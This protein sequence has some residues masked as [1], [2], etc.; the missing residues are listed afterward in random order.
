MS[1]TARAILGLLLLALTLNAQN[2]PETAVSDVSYFHNSEQVLGAG[3]DGDGFLVIGRRDTNL[4]AH[5]VT[6]GGAVLDSTGIRLASR[7]GCCSR[8]IRPQGQ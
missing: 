1:S 7:T 2:F 3:S 4:F 8:R 5:R 6:T